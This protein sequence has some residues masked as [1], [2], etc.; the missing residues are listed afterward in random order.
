M[1]ILRLKKLTS[2]CFESI[3]TQKILVVD[4]DLSRRAK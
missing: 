4:W 2:V 3:I 1:L